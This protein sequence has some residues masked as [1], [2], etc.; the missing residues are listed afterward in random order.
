MY[1]DFARH[2]QAS[3]RRTQ[4]LI[5]AFALMAVFALIRLGYLQL[6]CAADYRAQMKTWVDLRPEF[7]QP[8]RGDILDRNNTVLTQDA[9]SWQVEAYYGV[10]DSPLTRDGKSFYIVQEARRLL[11]AGQFPPG[12][13]QQQ[14]EELLQ[15]SIAL[16]WQ[17]ISE[18]THTP[19]WQILANAQQVVDR[20]RAIR[21]YRLTREGLEEDPLREAVVE[22]ERQFHPI[23]TDLS[24]STASAIR[25]ELPETQYRWLRVTTSSTR[26][27]ADDPSIAPLLGRLRMVSQKDLDNDP[28]ED[29]DLLKLRATDKVGDSGIEAAAEPLLRGRRGTIIRKRGSQPAPGVEPVRGQDVHLTIDLDLQEYIYKRLGKAVGDDPTASGAAAVVVDVDTREV[30]AAVSWPGYTR[31]EL[32]HKYEQLYK[33]RKH[34]PLLLRAFRAQYQPGSIAKPITV[35]GALNSGVVG[36]GE[37][38]NCTG[39]L[40]GEKRWR[41]WTVSHHTPPHGPVDAVAALEHSCNIYCV[42]VGQRLG[43]PRLTD[44]M[45]RFGLGATTGTGLHE[46]LDGLVPTPAWFAQ[47]QRTPTV[48]DVRNFSIGEGEVEVTPLQAANLGATIASGIWKPLTLIR[49]MPPT[50]RPAHRLPTAGQYLRDVR[51]GMNRV[52]NDP[53]GTAYRYARSDG[54]QIAGKTGTAEASQKACGFGYDVKMHDGTIRTMEFPT[55]D[56]ARTEFTRLGESVVSYKQTYTK[57]WP[58]APNPD[59]RPTHAWFMGFAPVGSPKIAVAVVIEYGGGG[60]KEASPVAR[61]IFERYFGV[62]G[63]HREEGD[64]ATEQGQ[65]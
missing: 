43:I 47:R 54:V 35:L 12:T 36:E 2:R 62:K 15:Q 56:D 22:Q 11:R 34:D 24:S 37:T 3:R 8:L 6:F 10:L 29:D 20:V 19:N 45:L 42:T 53:S 25:Q 26:Q 31:E 13:T 9:P 33:D 46:E 5:L 38:V 7:V 59:Q 58:F 64:A 32:A 1:D 63:Q 51:E 65:G 18:L 48:A 44:W 23:L 16:S 61:D 17:K 39:Y 49:E 14:A 57:W 27:Y 21:E 41:C 60:A 40:P 50:D 52:I 4:V 30:L 28:N 55:K